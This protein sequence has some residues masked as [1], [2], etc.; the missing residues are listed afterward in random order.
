MRYMLHDSNGEQ[1]A[2]IKEIEYMENYLD[3]ERLRLNEEVPITFE[4]EGDV[5][6]TR[7]TPL[8]LIAFLENAFKHGIGNNGTDSWITVSLKVAKGVLQYNVANSVVGQEE[9]TVR[10]ASGI[11]LANVRRRLDLSYPGNYQLD[12]TEDKE[13]YRVALN[14]NLT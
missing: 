3:L 12:I 14:I 10:E 9:K 1:V 11:G 7:I 5:V 8:I 2:L 13:R 4:V 6:G